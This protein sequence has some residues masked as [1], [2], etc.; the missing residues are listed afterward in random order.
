MNSRLLH[1][2]IGFALCLSL[3]ACAVPSLETSARTRGMLGEAL[4]STGMPPVQVDVAMP[5]KA[6]F[7][8]NPQMRA[9]SGFNNPNLVG[10]VYAHE[11][12]GIV[13]IAIIADAPS[14]SNWDLPPVFIGRPEN[15][16]RATMDG[17]AFMA[18]SR[19][20][21][22]ENDP[23]V[24]ALGGP[25]ALQGVSQWR[26]RRFEWL[27]TNRLTK[28]VLE[29][30][31]PM[32]GN[33]PED[34]DALPDRER[35]E[36]QALNMFTVSAGRLAPENRAYIVRPEW[37]GFMPGERLERVLGTFSPVERVMAP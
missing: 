2:L 31:L 4:V 5:M 25:D 9:Q 27:S 6:S 17:M 33:A 37:R 10:A 28:I 8:A 14:G 16:R 22:V 11:P 26:V 18:Y 36:A 19:W 21:P 15:L 32:R 29:Y 30:R 3:G 7:T 23:F 34:V 35:F 24:W 13:A 12:S 1:A 20:L